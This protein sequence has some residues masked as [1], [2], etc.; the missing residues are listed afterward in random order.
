MPWEKLQSPSHCRWNSSFLPQG[1]VLVDEPSCLSSYRPLTAMPS[2][3]FWSS[4]SP[5]QP[6]QQMARGN[7]KS[8]WT[9]KTSGD[10]AIRCWCGILEPC[11]MYIYIYTCD[12]TQPK[13]V[14]KDVLC[15]NITQIML[16]KRDMLY[17]NMFINFCQ[18]VFSIELNP[19]I[20]KHSIELVGVLAYFYLRKYP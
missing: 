3:G 13:N 9:R 17:M 16:W 6:I 1:S 8:N 7:D 14:V 15:V 10:G 11:L 12:V 2:W 18:H 5:K 4:R 19:N 20:A